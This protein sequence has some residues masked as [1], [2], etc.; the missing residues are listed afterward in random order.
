MAEP[1][2]K[3]LT[4]YKEFIHPKGD[5]GAWSGQLRRAGIAGRYSA[6]LQAGGWAAR[7]ASGI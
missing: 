1:N 6:A 5:K 3:T 7:Q 4:D 2:A